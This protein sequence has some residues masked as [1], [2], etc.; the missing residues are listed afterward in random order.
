MIMQCLTHKRYIQNKMK[1]QPSHCKQY[2][3][4][5]SNTEFPLAELSVASHL[6]SQFH[7][8]L[9]IHS[10]AD[11]VCTKETI[12]A[13]YIA[14]HGGGKVGRYDLSILSE[15]AN[16]LLKIPAVNVIN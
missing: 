5:N 9:G 13:T 4:C 7:H 10:L 12:I 6:M 16:P 1:G 15:G 2:V 3:F 8:D 11:M 14:M